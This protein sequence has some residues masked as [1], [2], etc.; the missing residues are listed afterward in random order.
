MIQLFTASCLAKCLAKTKPLCYYSNKP[1]PFV[2]LTIFRCLLTR[3]DAAGV[4]EFVYSVQG[5]P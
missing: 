5:Y 2:L 3:S 4:T 1:A